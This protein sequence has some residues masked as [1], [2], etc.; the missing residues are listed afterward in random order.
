MVHAGTGGGRAG[1]VQGAA[2]RSTALGADG[3]RQKRCKAVSA[4]EF[5]TR[6][7]RGRR[8]RGDPRGG[9]G[10]KQGGGRQVGFFN[11]RTA[12]ARGGW[13]RGRGGAQGGGWYRLMHPGVTSHSI[14][15]R[16]KHRS[17]NPEGYQG[18]GGTGDTDS[19]RWLAVQGRWW[20]S[21]PACRRGGGEGAA[22]V[23]GGGGRLAQPASAHR[24]LAYFIAHRWH[25][26][27]MVKFRSRSGSGWA[28]PA[29]CARRSPGPPTTGA[30]CCGR[31]RQGA[32]SQGGG[33]APL[34]PTCTTW[35]VALPT[36]TQPCYAKHSAPPEGDL[37]QVGADGVLAGQ[38]VGAQALHHLLKQGAHRQRQTAGG[39]EGRLVRGGAA[40]TP[41]YP[42]A[43][44]PINAHP[45]QPKQLHPAPTLSS[46]RMRS[47]AARAQASQAP[48]LKAAPSGPSS[49]RTRAKRL[50]AGGKGA[51]DGGR[52]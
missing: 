49:L 32:G 9:R 10:V 14:Y 35:R 19:T 33:E 43:G 51:A 45:A 28:H 41:P 22:A 44:Q 5:V 15:H 21:R 13:Y 2:F 47:M 34:P 50:T 11:R 7:N 4:E 40:K 29:L 39:G 17:G 18:R 6:G 3:S 52:Q 42:Q 16:E 36:V 31:G 8:Y 25:A 37:G 26:H 38:Q 30:A 23:G 1:W 46:P 48:A 27:S 24:G 12:G 20:Y